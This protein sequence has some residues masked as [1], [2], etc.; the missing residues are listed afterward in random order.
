MTIYAVV[1]SQGF[2]NW[3]LLSRTL[4]VLD[5]VE[6]IVSG[7]AR[8][9]DQMARRWAKLKKINYV[10]YLPAKGTGKSFGQEAMIRNKLI[11][12][13]AEKVIACFG[14]NGAT[15]GTSATIEMAK[16]AGKPV[17]IIFSGEFPG[18]TS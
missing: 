11:V 6:C 1:G 18:A 14:P 8:G 16:K 15:P 17:T 5:D 4:D 7:G 13:H 2:T 10:E 9:A 12:D 3:G